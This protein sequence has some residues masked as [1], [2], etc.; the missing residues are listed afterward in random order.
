MRTRNI[1]D[2]TEETHIPLKSFLLSG[3]GHEADDVFKRIPGSVARYGFGMA[4][5]QS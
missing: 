1:L 5:A 3:L 4:N 2:V